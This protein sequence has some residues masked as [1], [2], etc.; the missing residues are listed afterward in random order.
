MSVYA[1]TMPKMLRTNVVIDEDLVRKVMEIYGLRSKRE[2]VNFALRRAA[3]GDDPWS[4]M[5]ELRGIG[6]D[7]DLNEMRGGEVDPA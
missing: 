1:Q 6:W 4:G 7:G 5:R 2:A 3:G